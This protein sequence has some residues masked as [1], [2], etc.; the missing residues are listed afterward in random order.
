MLIRF[1]GRKVIVAGA[2]RGIGQAIARSF[3]AD[4]AEVLACDLLVDALGPLQGTVGGGGSIQTLSVDVTD[5]AS[6]GRVVA[7]AGGQVDVLVYVAGG[8]RGQTSKPLEEVSPEDFNNVVDVNLKG[9]FL[10]AK[11]VVPGMKAKGDGRIITISSRAGLATSLTGIQSYAARQTRPD[12]AGEAA[13]PGAGPIGHNRQFGR[14]RL[15]D[16]EPPATSVSGTAPRQS[17]A[18]ISR[19]ESRCA[20]W[21][22]PKTSPMR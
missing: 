13:R 8:V 16:D 14:S 19:T 4:G 11:A 6:I 1:D 7:E 17:S 2:A 18:P 22:V 20:A 3:A 10:F 15:H 5:E 9:A 12:R 21:A